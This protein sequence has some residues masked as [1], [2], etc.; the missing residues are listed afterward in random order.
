MHHGHHCGMELC[1]ERGIP[2]EALQPQPPRWSL[3][4]VQ[5]AVTGHRYGRVW[6][7]RADTASQ[8]RNDDASAHPHVTPALSRV[9]QHQHPRAAP[10][11]SGKR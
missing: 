5:A 8:E 6:V 3:C 9:R 2:G 1:N 10:L 7:H 11:E 4:A